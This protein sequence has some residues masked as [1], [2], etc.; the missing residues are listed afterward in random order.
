ML[1]SGRPW[2]TTNDLIGVA[3]VAAAWAATGV[4]RAQHLPPLAAR[5]A[6]VVLRAQP[7]TTAERVA[8]IERRLAGRIDGLVPGALYRQHLAFRYE[9][10][11]GRVLDMHPCGWH[12]EVELEGHDHLADALAR[13]RGAIL[14]TMSFCGHVVPKLGISRR[15][16]S[17]VHLSA[18][19]HG[20]FSD[21]WVAA[22][23]LNR[24]AQKSENRHLA[25]RV[26]MPL[27]WS[28]APLR[29]LKRRLSEN[30]VVSIAGEHR[31]DTGVAVRVLG[32]PAVFATGAPALARSTG[33]A[34]LT[35]HS[36][37][38]APNRYTVVIEPVVAP[39][40]IGNLESGLEAVV[41]TFARRLERHVIDHPAD[42]DRWSAFDLDKAR[43]PARWNASPGARA[44]RRRA[45]RRS[46][47]MARHAD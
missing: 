23:V 26:V 13:G 7:R 33:A 15:G 37:R 27:T 14:W 24:W 46:D 9:H 42:W 5:L 45:R 6:T 12:P 38:R 18:A 47:P 35:V 43:P 32:D 39:D 25:E 19:L 10:L 41:Q 36:Y 22:N 28:P 1:G 21:S 3:E 17:L 31:S 44:L 29:T 8:V 20:G 30:A 40:T 2:A 11:L 16:F 34:L 4:L